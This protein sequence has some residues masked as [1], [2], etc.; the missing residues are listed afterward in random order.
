MAQQSQRISRRGFLAA[1][2]LAVA[3]PL[4]FPS[5]V[6]GRSGVI[7]PSERIVMGQIGIGNMGGGLLG[8][9]TRDRQNFQMV[10]ICD[11]H[12][13][14]VDGGV[15]RVNSVYENSDCRG[16]DRYEDVLDRADIDAVVIATPDHWHTKMSIEACKAGKD[17]FCEKPLTHTPVESRQIVAAARKYN[18]VCCSGSQRVMEDY[19]YMAPVIQSGAIGEVKEAF[20]E[21]GAA[22]TDPYY[23]EEPIPGGLDW[24][25]WL[26]P[27]PMV[28]F[29]GERFSGN[30]GGGWRRYADYGNGFLADWGTH[31]LAG[32]TYILGIDHIEPLEILPPRCEGNPTDYLTLVYPGGI[33]VRHAH[34]HNAVYD[35]TFVGS[36]G[37][38]RH[39]VDRH[40]IKPLRQVDV[41]RYN[42]GTTNLYSD[43][44]YSVRHRLRPFQDFLYAAVAATSCQLAHYGYRVNRPLKWDAEKTAFIDDEQA[45]R[46]VSRPK[47]SPYEINEW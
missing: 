27:A 43:F 34:G 14:R 45:N 33:N 1:G 10:A 7:P 23:P 32:I 46:F 21:V 20:F 44:A 8:I 38:F 18:R 9:F 28:P 3:S 2:A 26:G 37:R 12:R 29:H 30:F 40:R 24:C 6:L 11:C 13:R 31:K 36:E 15:A 4:V 17:V 41:R 47:R 22:P 42:G 25:R 19:G 5:N 16:Y 35:V 39:Q